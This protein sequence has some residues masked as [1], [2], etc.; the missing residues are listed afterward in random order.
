MFSNLQC[1]RVDDLDL[2]QRPHAY[3]ACALT[4][5]PS[6]IR[7]VENVS[8]PFVKLKRTFLRERCPFKAV[9]SSIQHYS[10]SNQ[11][12]QSASSASISPSP[13]SSTPLKQ[14]GLSQ[15]SASMSPVSLPPLVFSQLGS[16]ISIQPSP[17]SSVP[18]EHDNPGLLGVS[19]VPSAPAER[20][21]QKTS[22]ASI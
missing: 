22:N 19:A 10:L 11:L 13:S 4:S 6:P 3:Q 9:S 1:Q 18:F 15:C 17:S 21:Q 2:N 14:V 16:A 7:T 8:L 5:E 20:S 12:T